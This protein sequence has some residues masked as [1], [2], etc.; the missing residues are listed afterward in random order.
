M[1]EKERNNRKDSERPKANDKRR[2]RDAHCQTRSSHDA[3]ISCGYNGMPR[4]SAASGLDEWSRLWTEAG[5]MPGIVR[6]AGQAPRQGIARSCA[7][8]FMV[9]WE[10][11]WFCSCGCHCQI[12]SC[13]RWLQVV[14]E[15]RP[16]KYGKRCKHS[17]LLL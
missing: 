15:R 7:C 6:Y 12:N 8:E 9:E 11:K 1:F 5:G 16:H 10:R 3:Y 4:M 2:S 14:C 13:V 17:G